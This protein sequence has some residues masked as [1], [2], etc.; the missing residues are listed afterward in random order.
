[1]RLEELGT[2]HT[3]V[4]SSAC[5]ST[6]TSPC[7]SGIGMLERQALADSLLGALTGNAENTVLTYIDREGRPVEIVSTG[8]RPPAATSTTAARRCRSSA[9]SPPTADAL[10]SLVLLQAGDLGLTHVDGRA[11]TSIPSL[12]RP[13]QTLTELTNEL[14][15]TLAN[16]QQHEKLRDELTAVRNQV[17]QAEDGTARREYAQIL[18]ELERVRA[19]AAALQSGARAPNGSSPARVGR[20]SP[21]ARAALDRSGRRAG[22][23]AQFAPRRANRRGDARRRPLL[24]G[25]RRRPICT[26]LLEDLERGPRRTATVSTP[27]CVSWPRHSCPTVRPTRS[28]HSWR[29]RTRTS[30]GGHAPTSWSRPTSCSASESRSAAPGPTQAVTDVIDRIEDTHSV[31]EEYRGARRSPRVPSSRP[32]QWLPS[33][34]SCSVPLVPIVSVLLLLGSG[35]R[36]GRRARPAR[37]GNLPPPAR[38]R[39]K[40]WASAGAPTYLG[41]H[42]RRVEASMM[43]GAHG[44]LEAATEATAS[45]RRAGTNWRTACPSTMRAALED[46]VR[47]LRHGPG[48]ARQLRERGRAPAPRAEPSGRSRPCSTHARHSPTRA[49]PTA[50]TMPRSRRA[51]ARTIERLIGRTRSQLGDTGACAGGARGGRGRRAEARQ[52]TRRPAAPARV[53]RRHARGARRRARLGRRPRHRARGGTGRGTVARRRSK[54]TSSRLQNEARRLRRPEWASVQAVGGRTGRG[55]EELARPQG[56][57]RASRSKV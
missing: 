11:S 40:R 38:R 20:G 17:R 25:R 43:P 55:L 51:D 32:P 46:E 37:C 6:N 49:R 24:S 7:L 5:A 52:P 2:A 14:Q 44:R 47:A 26:M 23:L 1:M 9:P 42:I 21:R 4:T 41:F 10:R 12:P 48:E 34:A 28:S 36:R 57:A 19:E 15:R 16:R 27:G 33:A 22:R 39:R 29:R 31:V 30:C 3:R 54:R 18:A 56:R 50:S 35:G 53:P 13:E 45:L 8:A